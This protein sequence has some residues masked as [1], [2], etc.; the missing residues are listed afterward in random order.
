MVL[1]LLLTAL[2]AIP[3][4]YEVPYSCRDVLLSPVK[5]IWSTSLLSRQMYAMIDTPDW[6]Q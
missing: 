4:E 2:S 6:G 3:T 1:A 5:K